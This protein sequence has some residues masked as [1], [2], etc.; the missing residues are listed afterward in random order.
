MAVDDAM[1]KALTAI[2][3]KRYPPDERARQQTLNK[4]EDLIWVI[5]CYIWKMVDNILS[6]LDKSSAEQTR[7]MYDGVEPAIGRPRSMK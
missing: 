6:W 7:L 4:M 5:A 1:M 2:L 3:M